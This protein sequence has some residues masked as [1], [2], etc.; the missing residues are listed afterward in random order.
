VD[1]RLQR[2]D[3]GNWYKVEGSLDAHDE[4]ERVFEDSFSGDYKYRLEISGWKVE[5]DRT[6][7]GTNSIPVHFAYFFEDSDRDDSDGPGTSIEP[8]D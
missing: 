7:C 1:L 8:E 4:K 5:S 6:V 2:W 3:D